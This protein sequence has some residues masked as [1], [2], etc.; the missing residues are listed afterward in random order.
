MDKKGNIVSS[1]TVDSESLVD[2]LKR[3]GIGAS[4]EN[5]KPYGIICQFCKRS[6]F[7]SI[8]GLSVHVRH[9]SLNPDRIELAKTTCPKCHLNIVNRGF[10]G[11]V[12]K[13]SGDPS[14]FIRAKALRSDRSR[15]RTEASLG[16]K[17]FESFQYRGMKGSVD[18]RVLPN[19]DVK[20]DVTWGK[21]IRGDDSVTKRVSAHKDKIIKELTVEPNVNKGFDDIVSIMAEHCA[22]SMGRKYREFLKWVEDSKNLWD[23]V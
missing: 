22:S 9:C 17:D 19:G 8:G 23:S 3:R 15:R 18:Y 2:K 14:K 20:T 21:Q 10:D 4:V 1:Y 5:A 16:K 6:D 13:C 7:K 12:E 11:H